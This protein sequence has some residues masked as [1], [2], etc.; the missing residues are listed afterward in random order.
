M[1]DLTRD[2][3]KYINEGVMIFYSKDFNDM[4]MVF[5]DG[6]TL[7]TEQ[8]ALK[9][10][11]MERIGSIEGEDNKRFVRLRRRNGQEAN[12]RG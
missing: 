12:H 3:V 11:D 6:Y 5:K 10:V 1:V 4:I 8:R 7:E 9:T 2:S